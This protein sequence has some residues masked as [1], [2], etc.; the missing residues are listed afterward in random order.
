MRKFWHFLVLAV[1]GL[2]L[3]VF[4]PPLLSHAALITTGSGLDADNAVITDPAGKVQS[5]T[6]VLSADVTYKISYRWSFP[7]ATQIKPGDTALVTLPQNINPNLDVDASLPS[8]TGLAKVGQLNLTAGSYVATITFNSYFYYHTANKQ[9]NVWFKFPG[10]GTNTT[11]PPTPTKPIAMS[12]TA[13]WVDPDSPDTINWGLNI[14]SNGNKL[15]NPVITDTLSADQTYVP[16]SVSA[17]NAAGEAVPVAATVNGRQLTFKL[18]GTYDSDLRLTYQSKTTNRTT[19][20]FNNNAVYRDD[21]GN[22]ATATADVDRTEEDE[23]NTGTPTPTK[24]ISMT[25][26]ASWVDANDKSKI[27]WS[28]A[29]T[30]NGNALV[31]PTI[32]DTLS[33]NH[34][35][36]PNSVTAT[37][38]RIPI[39]ITA[40]VNG[41]QVIFKIDETVNSDLTI[42]YQTQAALGAIAEVYRNSAVYSDEDDH[43]ATATDNIVL[44][45]DDSGGTTEPENPGTTEPENPGTTEPENPG[46]TE[47]ENPGTTEP[48][49][50]GT[51]E[52]EK[53]GTTEPEK[54]G[55]TEPEKPGTTEPEK[56]GTTEPEKPGTTEP[57]RPGTTEPEK[58]GTTEPEKPGT[59]EPEKPSPTTPTTPA[60]PSRPG[61]TPETSGT[62]PYRPNAESSATGESTNATNTPASTASQST[63]TTGTPTTT[64][65]TTTTT[66][67]S[68][69]A[70]TLPQTSEQPSWNAVIAGIIGLVLGTLIGGYFYLRS[71][72]V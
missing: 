35:Y 71:R 33:S 61:L 39:P 34:T 60:A 18:A 19:L 62:V 13:A 20:D 36:I 40:T 49:K 52:P 42:N 69:N 16:G 22:Q 1:A 32:T 43:T 6:A 10:K 8:Y 38:E 9:G 14:T 25:K 4:S 72:K 21:N 15:V 65:T 27:N 66:P 29:I 41:N 63:M 26:T 5:H 46:T 48:E 44:T 68:K 51:T 70:A 12:K 64:I 55:T 59:T 30:S 17:T 3:M 58:P 67:T 56:P 53:P 54:P 7:N 28:L 23:P 2:A 37:A 11:T 57:E 31:K 47:P 45:P 50:P 24:P